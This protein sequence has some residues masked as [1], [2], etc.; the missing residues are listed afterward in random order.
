MFPDDFISRL[1]GELAGS[2]NPRVP[3][4]NPYTAAVNPPPTLS[5]D[6]MMEMVEEAREARRLEPRIFVG[7][8]ALLP[9][10]MVRMGIERSTHEEHRMGG[11]RSFWGIDIRHDND[12]PDNAFIIEDVERLK[13][14]DMVTGK[15]MV[16]NKTKLALPIH[17]SA[18]RASTVKMLLLMANRGS[19]V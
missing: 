13:V 8:M 7:S 3:E 11:F 5:L 16:M 2:V 9:D 15:G 6:K 17:D 10:F 12:L 1:M 19:N 4:I 14:F 18:E